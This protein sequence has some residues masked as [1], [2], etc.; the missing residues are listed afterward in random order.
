MDYSR[1]K[2]KLANETISEILTQYNVNCVDKSW[3]QSLADIFVQEIFERILSD[4]TFSL[5]TVWR[6]IKEW[7][8]NPYMTV[9][10]GF[11]DGYSIMDNEGQEIMEN[12]PAAM[13]FILNNDEFPDE[14]QRILIYKF[15]TKSVDVTI[16]IIGNDI[17]VTQIDDVPVSSPINSEKIIIPAKIQHTPDLHLLYLILDNIWNEKYEVIDLY[18]K[19]KEERLSEER[20]SYELNVQIISLPPVEELMQKFKDKTNYPLLWEKIHITG[21]KCPNLEKYS[22]WLWDV[23]RNL[24]CSECKWHMI[25]Y[26]QLNPPT[27]TIA[28]NWVEEHYISFYWSWVFH[29]EVNK[30]L[31][32]PELS[33]KDAL[34]Y[35]LK[36]L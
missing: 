1:L 27:E 7:L 11:D 22:E 35:F 32:K 14:I 10:L 17:Q 6:S 3:N 28:P 2:K 33:Y 34:F 31:Y 16:Q 25:R 8:R 20:Y 36:L 26:I 19:Y 4:A 21:I 5:M 15:I 29:N 12:D 13:Y 30:R 9:Q 23:S 18:I 24:P